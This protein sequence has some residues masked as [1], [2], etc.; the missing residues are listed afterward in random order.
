MQLSHSISASEYFGIDAV[1]QTLLKQ[2]LRSP[3]HAKA[4]LAGDKVPTSAMM[5]G[6]AA[7]AAIL[8]PENFDNEVAIQ[9]DI[10]RRTK[11][12]KEQYKR[13]LAS[14][15][16]K[17]II[18]R[19]Q[20]VDCIQVGHSVSRSKSAVD[21][22]R[23]GA[24]EQ[25]FVWVDE[26]TKLTCKARLDVYDGENKKVV[27][28]KTTVDASP[29][30]FARSVAKFGYHIQAAF[31]LRAAS[32]MPT[33]IEAWKD[34]WRFYIVAVET[35]SPYAVASYTLDQR[36]IIEGDK[37]VDQALGVWSEC[38]LLDDFRGYPDTVTSLSLPMWALTE[39]EDA[40]LQGA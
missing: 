36:A 7:H 8:N 33:A 25:S 9:P 13:F 15:D 35:S 3:A 12:G 40:G 11:D 16:G 30:G 21:L 34:G 24:T 28:L 38:Q 4:Y 1:N 19:D 10:N 2:V 26:K 14:A 6:T 32:R 39:P 5:L 27:D 23:S 31:Y 17:A 18:N 37:K 22:L 20:S 29:D